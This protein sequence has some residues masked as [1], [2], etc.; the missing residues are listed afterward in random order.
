MGFG[1]KDR[2]VKYLKECDG[3]IDRALE[4]LCIDDD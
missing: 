2:C 3:D 4:K 1:D